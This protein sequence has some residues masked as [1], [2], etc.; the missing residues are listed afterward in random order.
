MAG[1]VVGISAVL[2]VLLAAPVLSAQDEPGRWAFEPARDE[3]RA[4]ALLDLRSL[5]EKTAGESGFVRVGPDGQ[6]VLGNGKPVRFWSCFCDVDRARPFVAKPLSPTKTEPDLAHAAR[7]F[8]KRGINMVRL[9]F[10]INPNLAKDPDARATDINLEQRDYIWRAVAAMKKEGIYSTICPYWSVPA[11]LGASWN[12]PGGNKQSALGLLF[13]DPTL[14]EAYKAWMKALYTEKNPYTGIP[15]AQDPAAAI[16]QIQNEDSLL[17]WTFASIKGEQQKSLERKFAQWVLKKYGS[18][19]AAIAK[20]GGHPI[21]GDDTAQGLLG[22]INIWEMT[23]PRKE[24]PRTI[25][26]DDQT[27]FI[28][29]IDH[30][31]YKMMGQY[32]RKDLGCR[33][34]INASNWRTASPD[35]LADAERWS[36]TPVDVDAVNR[37][38]N[39]LHTGPNAGW[40]IQPGDEFTSPSILLDPKPLPV[41]L[42]Q[43][44]GRPMI[45]TES[46]WVLPNAHASEGPFLTSVYSSLNGVASYYWF[47]TDDDE[48]TQ[49]QSANGYMPNSQ[50]MWTFANPDMLGNF[51]AAALLFRRGYVARSAPVVSEQRALADIWQRRPPLITEEGAF[52]PIRDKGNMAT[53]SSVKTPVN[54]LAFLVGRV[55]VAFGGDPAKSKVAD[56]SKYIDETNKTVKSATGEIMLDYGK[57]FCTVNSP[58]A[59]GVSAFFNNQSSFS[60]K[61]VEISSGNDYGTVLVVSMDDTPLARSRKVLVQVGTQCRPTGWA[62]SAKQIHVKEGNFDGFTVDNVGHA[63]WQV[64]RANVTVTVKNPSLL[65]ATI[66]DMNGNSTGDATIEKV[67]GGIRFKFPENAMYVVLQ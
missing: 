6:F 42:K 10:D 47:T 27:E 24:G 22:F 29:G 57:G 58:R 65:H 66:L 25:R 35:F 33:Q 8:A 46:A 28:A 43:T 55:E 9:G 20:W 50:R 37:Y 54:P 16:L 49:P 34:L 31:F 63:P 2:G 18:L 62:E 67:P 3:F 53:R 40:S 60:L 61:D 13:F 48:W 12:I 41:S 11:K 59:Q 39:G 15:L 23:L 7:F 38:Y 4:D 36:Y 52:D 51:P 30:D 21:D 14:Q 5:N 32:L 44:V 19:D 17:F 64:V 45:I 26:L 56:L 1:A